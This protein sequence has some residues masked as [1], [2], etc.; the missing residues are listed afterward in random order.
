MIKWVSDLCLCPDFLT[1]LFRPR[2][3]PNQ[4]SSFVLLVYL[5]VFPIHH[6][7]FCPKERL[8]RQS[9]GIGYNTVLPPKEI[10]LV[11]ISSAS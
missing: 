6:K 4:L 1:A 10:L 7:R 5:F 3:Q 8:M 9:H 2:K 11:S